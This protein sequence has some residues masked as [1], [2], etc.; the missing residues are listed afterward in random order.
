MESYS[1]DAYDVTF[2]CI[3]HRSFNFGIQGSL[4]VEYPFWIGAIS[5]IYMMELCLNAM[6]LSLDIFGQENQFHITY[7]SAGWNSV[8]TI[9]QPLI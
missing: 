6:D 9:H 3:N 1:S 2:T 8:N 5:N 4:F 7:I